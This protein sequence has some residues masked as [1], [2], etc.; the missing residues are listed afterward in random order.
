[1]TEYQIEPL[2]LNSVWRDQIGKVVSEAFHNDSAAQTLE[3]IEKTTATHGAR[4][5]IYFGAIEGGEL[6][7]FNAF[8]RHEL[9]LAGNPIIA[10]QSCWTAT[11]SAHRGKRVFQNIILEAHRAL[12]L[13][14]GH[15]VIGW[16]N[17]SSEPLFVHKLGYRREGSVKRNIFGPM[18][19]HFFGDLE[20]RAGGINQNDAQLI[21]L[22]R[23]LHGDRLIVEGDGQDLLWGVIRS[24][25]T[26]LGPI[27]YFEVGGLRWSKPSGAKLLA[28]GMRGRLPLVAYWQI[29]SER[30]NTINPA[31]GKFQESSTNPL[32]WYPLSTNVSDGPFDFFGGI[33]DVY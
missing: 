2:D 18:A 4:P 8:I 24:R 29:I 22:K 11:S 32:I 20:A 9:E 16:P 21:D 10:Y 3:R 6:I 13:E 14:G 15:F 19:E 17:P 27:P 5:S 30:R 23:G 33:R 26:R 28:S 12:A 25:P 31:I 7:G 1:M